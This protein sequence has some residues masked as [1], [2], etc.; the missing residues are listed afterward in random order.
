VVVVS[1]SATQTFGSPARGCADQHSSEVVELL[2]VVAIAV[3]GVEAAMHRIP[4]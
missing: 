3:V 1:D 4:M 2:E